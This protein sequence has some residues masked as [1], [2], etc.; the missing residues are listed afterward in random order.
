MSKH[1]HLFGGEACLHPAIED[2]LKICEKD[3]PENYFFIWTN[4]KYKKYKEGIVKTSYTGSS[5][6]HSIYKNI[7]VQVDL[8]EEDRKFISTLIAPQDIIFKKSKRQFF[9]EY[10]QNHCNMY[11]NCHILF[12]D[13]FAYACECAGSFDKITEFDK[14]WII[15]ENFLESISDE[16]VINQ[17]SNFCYRCGHCIPKNI[18]EKFFQ[19]I[20]KKPLC[21]TTNKDITKKEI[22]TIDFK[23]LKIL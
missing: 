20:L 6:H 10:A 4:G 9:E 2:F 16:D 22:N 11:K 15:Q 12:Y 23:K 3:H 21:S 19:S 14:G 18:R 1:V 5:Y 7:L 13:K 17:L 8:K